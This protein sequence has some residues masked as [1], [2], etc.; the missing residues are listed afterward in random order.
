MHPAEVAVILRE[1]TVGGR[2]H[3]ISNI[4]PGDGPFYGIVR[5][6]AAIAGMTFVGYCTRDIYENDNKY[7]YARN[8][9][10][11]FGDWRGHNA[12]FKNTIRS[13][14]TPGLY[15]MSHEVRNK[16]AQYV[17]PMVSR[18]CPA[19]VGA[20][21]IATGHDHFDFRG[22]TSPRRFGDYQAHSEAN[23]GNGLHFGGADR[24]FFVPPY[25]FGIGILTFPQ[26][27]KA[28]QLRD[29]A[30]YNSETRSLSDRF[31]GRLFR[32]R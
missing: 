29:L 20:K 21:F 6:S 22:T 16:S 17:W 12:R 7:K 28:G 8:N 2:V 3:V 25:G 10:Y 26:F 5:P 24:V 31:D 18:N 9:G 13:V 15:L 14:N 1:L 4:D 11:F 23:L 30:D 19:S 32:Q 27:P